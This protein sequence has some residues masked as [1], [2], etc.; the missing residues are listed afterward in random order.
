MRGVYAYC[1]AVDE[2]S[3]RL[4]H[5][6]CVI[7]WVPLFCFVQPALSEQ[8]FVAIRFSAPTPYSFQ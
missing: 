1:L 2:E 8:V 6:R 7:H 3:W 5:P 4:L